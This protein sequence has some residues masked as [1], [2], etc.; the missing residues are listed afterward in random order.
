MTLLASSDI[1]HFDDHGEA[2]CEVNVT[3][4]N[5]EVEALGDEC[6]A[7]EDQKAQR[8]HFH[9]GMLIDEGADTATEDHHK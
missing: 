6:G 4:G 9:G 7:D 8:E 1:E 2:H 3:F 5:V